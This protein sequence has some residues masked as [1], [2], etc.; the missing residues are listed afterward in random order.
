MMNKRMATV[1]LALLLLVAGVLLLTACGGGGTSSSES[2]KTYTVYCYK[3]EDGAAAEEIKISSETGNTIA[4]A[5]K[6]A[7]HLPRLLHCRGHPD[8]QR[9]G[10]AGRGAAH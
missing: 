3:S 8:L 7:L 6:S 10:Q 1:L 4:P 2:N 5:K 9:L